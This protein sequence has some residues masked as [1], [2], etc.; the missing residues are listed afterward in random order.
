MDAP[1]QTAPRHFL[2]L[3]DLSAAE[4]RRI[5]DMSAAMK[6][7]RMK[8]VAS[9]ARPL[10]GKTLAMVFDRPST[11]TRVSFDVAMRELGG[12]AIVIRILAE[13]DM[14]EMAAHAAVPV[15]NGLTKQSHPCQVLAD[16]LTFEE[17]RGH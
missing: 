12:E 9:P 8:G 10:A 13:A 2:G 1:V 15:I 7:A 17:K 11:R 14:L 16:I 3:L 5:L 6:K 4:L